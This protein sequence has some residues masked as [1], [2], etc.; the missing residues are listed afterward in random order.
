MPQ[1]LNYD[2]W[3]GPAPQRGYPPFRTGDSTSVHFHW[4]WWWD[5]GGGVLAD[6]ACHYMD[7]PHWALNLRQ[8]TTVAAQGQNHLQGR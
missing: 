2:L 3:L 1:G 7:L 4:R 5:F 6:M 8:P